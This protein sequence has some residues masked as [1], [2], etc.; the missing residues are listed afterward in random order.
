ME[1]ASEGECDAEEL[2]DDTCDS[3]AITLFIHYKMLC[4]H[5]MLFLEVRQLMLHS[6]R[7]LCC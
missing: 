2:H 7:H 1:K 3:R 5:T 6:N 4:K